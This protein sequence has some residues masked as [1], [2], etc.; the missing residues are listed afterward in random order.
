MP[1][2]IEF[3]TVNPPRVVMCASQRVTDSLGIEHDP[4][5]AGSLGIEQDASGYRMPRD[6]VLLG[7]E[8]DALRLAPKSGPSASCVVGV[9]NE[10]LYAGSVGPLT[11]GTCT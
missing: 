9:A 5:D 8:Q 4:R 6:T 7:I 2:K 3:A 10:L 1:P 11:M